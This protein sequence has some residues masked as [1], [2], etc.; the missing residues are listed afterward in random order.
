MSP[1]GTAAV[2][3]REFV[4]SRGTVFLTLMLA[5][6]VVLCAFDG[7]AARLSSLSHPGV[8]SCRSVHAANLPTSPGGEPTFRL[9]SEGALAL[10]VGDPSWLLAQSIDHPPELSA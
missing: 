9:V 1:V 6:L 3:V 2:D 10:L 5:L 8:A 4:K 7:P